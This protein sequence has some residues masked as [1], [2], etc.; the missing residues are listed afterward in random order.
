[1]SVLKSVAVFVLALLVLLALPFLLSIEAPPS[2]NLPAQGMPWQIEHLPDGSTRIFGLIPGRSTLEEARRAL[3]AEPAVALIQGE[4]DTG[5]LEAYLDTYAIG[6]LTGKMILTLGS[7]QAEREAMLGRALKGEYMK[8]TTKRITLAP[9]DLL[10]AAQARVVAVTF[11][12]SAQLDEQI[13]LERFGSPN[14]RIRNSENTE[15]FLYPALGLDIQ[16]DRKGREL[17]Q[18]VSPADFARL[19]E[20][21]MLN[22]KPAK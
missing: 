2:S 20:P 22:N 13:L 8:S 11:I 14:E 18:Y 15:H 12:P 9:A 7:T 19:R 6:A 21:L 5:S 10:A 16:L 17:L 3:A 4:N 1:M